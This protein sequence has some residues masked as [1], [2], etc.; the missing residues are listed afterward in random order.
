MKK[1]ISCTRIVDCLLILSIL[2][3]LFCGFLAIFSIYK[4]D[5]SLIAP[6]VI[7]FLLFMTATAFSIKYLFKKEELICKRY[8]IDDKSIAY[9]HFMSELEML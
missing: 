6:S 9:K 4:N 2:L 1:I 7:F 3:L 8:K 5:K